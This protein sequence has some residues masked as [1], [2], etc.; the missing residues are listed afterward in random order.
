MQSYEEVGAAAVQRAKHVSVG[1]VLVKRTRMEE[2]KRRTDARP[3]P[4]QEVD[5][6]RVPHSPPLTSQH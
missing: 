4:V 3:N 5:F 1:R 6:L 2:K